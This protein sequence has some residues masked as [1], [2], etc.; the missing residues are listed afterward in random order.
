MPMSYLAPFTLISSLLCWLWVPTW[1]LT[2]SHLFCMYIL[3]SFPLFILSLN[4]LEVVFLVTSPCFH[5]CS[6]PKSLLVIIFMPYTHPLPLCSSNLYSSLFL[7]VSKYLHL[8]PKA[9]FHSSYCIVTYK[10]HFHW[11][12]TISIKHNATSRK[13]D[14]ICRCMHR[15]MSCCFAFQI[16]FLFWY[17]WNS[18]EWMVW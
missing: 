4:H 12:A 1:P 6:E 2:R 9:G 18:S 16:I 11:R 8:C 17:T 5:M 13:L 10:V 14:H 3:V 15:L 7:P